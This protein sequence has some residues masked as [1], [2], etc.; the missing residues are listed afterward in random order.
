MH[1]Y[2][3]IYPGDRARSHTI[4]FYAAQFVFYKVNVAR[5]FCRGRQKRDTKRDPNRENTETV[6]FLGMVALE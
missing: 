6:T 5:I 3:L 2:T 1:K 4:L